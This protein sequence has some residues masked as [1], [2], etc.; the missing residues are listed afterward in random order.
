M[1][2]TMAYWDYVGIMEGKMETTLMCFRGSPR[3]SMDGFWVA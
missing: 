1:E 3:T 2:T